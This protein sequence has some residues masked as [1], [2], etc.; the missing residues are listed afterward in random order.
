MAIHTGKSVAYYRVSTREQGEEGHSI[1]AQRATVRRHLNGGEWDLIEHFTEIESGRMRQRPELNA[2]IDMCI[3][4]GATLI[5]AKLDRLTR[6]VGFLCTF[7]ERRVPVIFC[8][9]PNM[10]NPAQN[11]MILQLMATVAEYEAALISE[12]TIAGLEAAKGK[13]VILGSPNPKAGSAV[14]AVKRATAADKFAMRV[15]PLIDQ[16]RKYGCASLAEIALGLEARGQLTARGKGRW[17]ASA[18]R[19]VILRW[20]E[21]KLKE[22][23]RVR[24]V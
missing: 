3:D 4:E 24:N 9:M 17:Q 19:N 15:G 2:A 21:L 6:N 22:D 8:D 16:L 1:D 13:G 10:H 11:K 14:A 7:I 5:C 23:A 12:R 20:E 18:V